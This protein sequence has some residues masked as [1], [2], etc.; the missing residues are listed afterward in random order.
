MT[1]IPIQ[2]CQYQKFGTWFVAQ[3]WMQLIKLNSKYQTEHSSQVRCLLFSSR[4]FME[5]NSCKQLYVAC[6]KLTIFWLWRLVWPVV[7]LNVH[8][9]KS[10]IWD[11]SPSLLP[12][13]LAS[14]I[15]LLQ[16]VGPHLWGDE[17]SFLCLFLIVWKAGY[18][19][20]VAGPY[21][22]LK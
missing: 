19:H 18:L 7:M 20:V 1:S 17:C 9:W 5:I 15:Y 10:K 3:I 16:N 14:K 12:S 13:C 11:P 21:T 4:W 2:F 8:V 6:C 22:L